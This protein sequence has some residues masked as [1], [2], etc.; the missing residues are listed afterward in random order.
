MDALANPIQDNVSRDLAPGR[1]GGWFRETKGHSGA[2]SAC[3][4]QV[5]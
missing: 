3:Q 4:G 2:F 5:L 1:G